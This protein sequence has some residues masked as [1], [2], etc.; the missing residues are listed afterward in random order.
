MIFIHKTNL[1]NK[2]DNK[3]TIKGHPLTWQLHQ[4]S[5]YQG[6]QTPPAL[7]LYTTAT[8]DQQPLNPTTPSL[9]PYPHAIQR[10]SD[11]LSL[12]KRKY[13]WHKCRT[14]TLDARQFAVFDDQNYSPS[15]DRH[16]TRRNGEHTDHNGDTTP[17]YQAKLASLGTTSWKQSPLIAAH[18]TRDPKRCQFFSCPFF[19]FCSLFFDLHTK[20][21]S[22]ELA[23]IKPQTG[24]CS[25]YQDVSKKGMVIHLKRLPAQ[26]MSFQLFCI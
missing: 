2:L 12:C 15:N 18:V 21:A 20:R 3:K 11:Y 7:V 24:C 26:S 14:K 9:V 8:N 10:D 23:T 4:A 13:R 1:I 5:T 16:H 19:A 6:Q 22:S 25:L 17:F